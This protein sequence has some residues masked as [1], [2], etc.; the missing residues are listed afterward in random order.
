MDCMIAKWSFL[1]YFLN[2]MFL[3]PIACLETPCTSIFCVD[4]V[5]LAHFSKAGEL[6][7]KRFDFV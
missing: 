1:F 5:L 3:I 6:G 2:Q 4:K 7:A